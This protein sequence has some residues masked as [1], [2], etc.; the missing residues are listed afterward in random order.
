M[1]QPF[2]RTRRESMKAK[3]I[4]FKMVSLH[5]KEFRAV[6]GRPTKDDRLVHGKTAAVTLIDGVAKCGPYIS[7]ADAKRDFAELKRLRVKIA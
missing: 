1:R 7:I 2:S 5:S 6:G 3:K 4:E